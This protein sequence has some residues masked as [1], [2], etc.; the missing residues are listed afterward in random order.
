MGKADF[1]NLLQG[2]RELKAAR[3]GELPA[4]TVRE[5]RWAGSLAAFGKNAAAHDMDSVRASIAAG[6]KK[7]RAP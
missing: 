7:E 3:R 1:A 2:V 6:R 4:G 5:R